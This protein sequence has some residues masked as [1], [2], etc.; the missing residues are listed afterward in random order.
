[1]RIVAVDDD[2]ESRHAEPHIMTEPHPDALAAAHASLRT[3][4]IPAPSDRV[5][6]AECQYC[7]CTAE[8]AGGLLVNLR[9]FQA[10]CT[11]HVQIDRN[12]T[13]AVLYLH[14]TQKRIPK[15]PAVG[16]ATAVEETPHK[17]AIGV[18]G[19]FTV[20]NAAFDIASEHAIVIFTGSPDLT[21]VAHRIPHPEVSTTALPTLVSLV[22]DA[23]IAHTDVAV[24]AA[25]EAWEDKPH[26][27][28]YAASLEQLPSPPRISPHASTWV[29]ADCD[30]RD[31]LWLNLS[32]GHIGC[33]RQNF[34]GTGGN[35][36]ALAHFRATGSRY[37]LCVKLGTIAADGGD[38]Y[39][40][41][42]DEDD[43]VVDEQ[44]SAHL[45][46]FGIA[47]G[48]L[49]K[50]EASMA[51]LNVALNGSYDFS[52][53]AESGRDLVPISG[54][55]FIGADNLGNSCYLN[56]VVQSLAALPEVARALGA[57]DVAE[58]VF[59]HA[60]PVSADDALTQ[61]VKLFVGLTGPA[62][63][64]DPARLTVGAPSPPVEP[65]PGGPCGYIVPRAFKA[66]IA[67]GS[68]DFTSGR[69]QDAI[70]YFEWLLVALDKATQAATA[71]GRDPPPGA[72][73]SS[74]FS[75]NLE[76]RMVDSASEGV[77]YATDAERFLR[78]A[79]PVSENVSSTLASDAATDKDS[80]SVGDEGGAATKK[81]RSEA[82]PPPLV[83]FEVCLDSWAAPAETQWRS[84]STGA[85]A[86]LLTRYR[87]ASFPRYLVLQ[88]GRYA[89]AADWTTRKV[90]A[91]VP[92]PLELDLEHLR[93]Q[94]R[95]AGEPEMPAEATTVTATAT[96][97]TTAGP[98]PDAAIV[99]ALEEAGFPAGACAR[100]ALATGN[101][102]TEDAMNWLISHMEDESFGDPFVPAGVPAALPLPDYAGSISMLV[103]MG[104]DQSRARHALR[105]TAGNVERAADW[106][107][108]HADDPLPVVSAMGSGISDGTSMSLDNTAGSRTVEDG[109]G[110]YMLAGFIS[111]IG[112]STASGHYVCHLRKDSATGLLPES[113]HHGQWVLF[114]DRKVA[115]SEAPPFDLGY[116]Y[117][118]KRVGTTT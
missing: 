102:S 38:V 40:Y 51:E 54:P 32:D 6:K 8:S 15:A 103:D 93:A 21:V 34:T 41:A 89:L 104:F 62:A 43:A 45:A 81:P 48:S 33:G 1:M 92:V 18:P 111:H 106:L 13:G 97:A 52:R 26:P 101:A 74:L 39:S 20:D 94:G 110:R 64:L 63:A 47:L 44:L 98:T 19:G 85:P 66:A 75:F 116:I 49:S 76:K 5:F 23:I 87:F 61:T 11:S 29:C 73:L 71:A 108:S 17:L 95:Q 27:S 31:N 24:A 69:Q 67:K 10:Y 53:I 112:T 100:A 37:P 107:F 30:K 28:K 65:G 90:D 36:H 86:T 105:E 60:P 78:L 117:I 22:A 118:Y 16:D 88:L 99:A 115:I 109:P 59:A 46:H 25:V 82:P 35:G 58:R 114:N 91:R 55:G 77:Q 50:T 14:T 2:S 56:S 42:P 9:T 70:E 57:A 84:P 7:Y 80:I 83:P 96:A 113:V 72:R 79:I 68:P 4:R 12:H 3:L